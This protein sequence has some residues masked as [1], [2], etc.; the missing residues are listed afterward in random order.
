MG[1]NWQTGRGDGGVLRQDRIL[2][3]EDEAPSQESAR[4]RLPCAKLTLGLI[5]DVRIP[6]SAAGWSKA[7]PTA[8]GTGRVGERQQENHR[9]SD[10]VFA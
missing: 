10:I 4:E 5:L 1:H 8:R 6:G 2:A 9:V 7:R 3:V